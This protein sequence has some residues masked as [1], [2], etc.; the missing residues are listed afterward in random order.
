MIAEWKRR[1]KMTHFRA[2]S[3]AAMGFPVLIATS[4]SARARSEDDAIRLSTERLKV[5]HRAL[6]AY[7]E[8]HREWPDHLS[9]LVPEFLPNEASLRDPADPGTGGLGSDQALP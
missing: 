6:V 7:R 1:S 5:I 4:S 2:L 8:K 3:L 9:S